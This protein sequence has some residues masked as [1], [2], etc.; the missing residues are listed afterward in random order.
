[1]T[2]LL[3]KVDFP[4]HSNDFILVIYMGSVVLEKKIKHHLCIVVIV[5][6]YQKARDPSFEQILIQRPKDTLFPSFLEEEMKMLKFNKRK[7]R[8]DGPK[9]TRKIEN[10][11]SEKK[12]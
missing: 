12:I 1:M 2:S 6:L 10:R 11:R 4:S 3:H 9:D 5:L 7:K 8:T